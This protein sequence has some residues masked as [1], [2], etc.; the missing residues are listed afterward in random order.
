MGSS[1]KN[2]M[3]GGAPGDSN[4]ANWRVRSYVYDGLSRITQVTT[5]EA[6]TVNYSFTSGGSPCSGDARLPCGRTDPRNIATTYS[7]DA[8]NRL[9]AKTYSD[10]TPA[11]SY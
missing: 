8:L 1:T 10:T 5:P 9:T 7:Y 6:G 11:I 4:S 3:K 2:E